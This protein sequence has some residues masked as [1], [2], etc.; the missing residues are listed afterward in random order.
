MDFVELSTIWAIEAARMVMRC[1]SQKGMILR[2]LSKTFLDANSPDC[3]GGTVEKTHFSDMASS[4][5]N[6]FL[7]SLAWD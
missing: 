5:T 2:S 1:L 3:A 4:S 7:N 6:Q